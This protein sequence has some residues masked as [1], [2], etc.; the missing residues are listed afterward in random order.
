MQGPG[1]RAWE[2]RCHLRTLP[3]MPFITA[4]CSGDCYDTYCTSQELGLKYL[5]GL[6]S[7][8]GFKPKHSA[9]ESMFSKQSIL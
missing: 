2:P 3:A 9:P 7:H 5:Q 6:L 1:A 4:L 8:L